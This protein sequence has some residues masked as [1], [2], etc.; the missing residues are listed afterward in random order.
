MQ[1]SSIFK[2]WQ[3]RSSPS[4]HL[5]H[6]MCV[7]LRIAPSPQ[8][9]T[10]RLLV[11]PQTYDRLLKHASALHSDTGGKAR[12]AGLGIDLVT[13]F[14]EVSILFSRVVE[15]SYFLDRIV[16]RYLL[17]LRWYFHL[18]KS[19]FHRNKFSYFVCVIRC[20]RRCSRRCWACRSPRCRSTSQ[21]PRPTRSCSRPTGT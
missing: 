3:T 6:L 18:A 19:V 8:H 17:D 7:L 2:K 12:G 10:H 5:V 15:I 21:A 20:T 13:Y 4:H 14:G 11:L 1:R 9:P 16:E